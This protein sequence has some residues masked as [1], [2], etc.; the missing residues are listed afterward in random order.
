MSTSLRVIAALTIVT[1]AVVALTFAT[2]TEDTTTPVTSAPSGTEAT[3]AGGTNTA[4][5]ETQASADSVG[6]DA[7]VDLLTVA[8]EG[9]TD[10]YDR[11]LFPHWLDG[12]GDGCDT[13]RE[14][15]IRDS[16]TDV[17]IGPRCALDGGFWLSTYD[18]YSTPDPTELEIDHVV[19][20]AEAWRSGADTWDQPTRRA[21]ANDLSPGALVAVTAAMNRIKSDR[22]PSSWQPP[23]RDAWCGYATAWTTT[24]IR[25][26]LTADPDEVRALRNMLRGCPDVA[27]PDPAPV[28]RAP[29]PT[30]GGPGSGCD[31]SYPDVCIPSP[32]PDLD[33]ADIA[34][35]RFTVVGA[36]PH[37]FDGD[38]NGI[39][40]EG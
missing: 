14:V 9:T 27:V 31:P 18:G 20:L 24:K 17:T 12:S 22:D 28:G 21:F 35:R 32:P 29:A 1:M 11:D 34:H 23:A 15:L 6:V 7:L 3:A 26:G 8:P 38:G 2:G 37:R 19:A 13:R 4:P 16:L 10:G 40:C 39:G 36:D 25:W 5:T 30:A 33:C